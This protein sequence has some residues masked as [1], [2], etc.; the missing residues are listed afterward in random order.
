VGAHRAIQRARRRRPTPLQP[1]R[2]E[3]R[4]VRPA[5]AIAHRRP[6]R[7]ECRT[8]PP[9]DGHACA[10]FAAI[11]RRFGYRRLHILLVRE[12]LVMNHKK[13]RRLYRGEGLQVR[14][15][16]G[17]KRAVGR[18]TPINHSAGASCHPRLEAD[19]VQAPRSRQ[20]QEIA[21]RGV[22]ELGGNWQ[23]L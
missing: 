1:L 19:A 15:R 6:I 10:S 17:R 7:S 2:A 12:G 22:G 14:R 11:R 21:S 20:H 23:S 4:I 13:L 3:D 9:F 16:F 8:R 5:A 18:R